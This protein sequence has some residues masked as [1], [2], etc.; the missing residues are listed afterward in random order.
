MKKYQHLRAIINRTYIN[1]YRLHI[2]LFLYKF[3]WYDVDP[4]NSNFWICPHTYH[5]EDYYS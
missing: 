5:Y 1:I 2:Y 4:I 3:Q